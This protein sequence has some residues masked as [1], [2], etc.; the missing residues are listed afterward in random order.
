MAGLV[1]VVEQPR[2][3]EDVPGYQLP[4]SALLWTAGDG[5]KAFHDPIVVPNESAEGAHT[6]PFF[7]DFYQVVAAQAQGIQAREHT[8]QVPYEDRV[9]REDDFREGKLAILY[10][11]PTMELG[12][13][14]KDLNVVNLR[15]IPPTPANYAQRSGRAGRSGQPA[16]VFAY[17]TT[18]SPH[19]QYFFKRPERMV[20][21]AVTP[22]RLDLANEDLVR[23]HVHAIWLAETHLSLG[24]SLKDILDLSG[25]EPTLALL[26]V[27]R[28]SIEDISPKRRAKARA[29]RVLATLREELATSDWDRE[30]WL[31]QELTLVGQ[32][33]EQACERWRGLYRAAMAQ[34]KAQD[35]VIRD[36]AR[37]AEDKR[38]A[39]RLRR[40]AEEQLKLLTEVENIVQSDF[41]S[42]RYFASEG[43]LPGYSFPRLPLSAFIPARRTKQRDEFLSRPRFLAISEFGPRAIVYHEG[44]RYII[45]KVILPVE[46]DNVLTRQAKLCGK[47]GYLHPVPD[48][49]G[50]DVCDKCGAPLVPPLRQLFRLQNVSTKRR[51]KINSDEEERMRQGYEI[52]TG[53]RFAEQGERPSYHSATIEKDGDEL[54][55]LTYGHSATLWRINLGWTR[56]K[57]KEQ[58]GFVLDVERGY[59]ARSDQENEDQAD[60]LSPRTERVIPFVEDRR[61]CLL[62][63]PSQKI[64]ATAMASLQSALK[65]AIQVQF[66]LEDNELAAEP[67]PDADDRR[68][69]LLYESAEGGAGVLRRLLDDPQA[70]ALVAQEALRLCHFDPETGADLHRA[71]RAREDCEA[72]C[73]DCL[74][75]YYNQRDHALLD[76]QAIRDLL[77]QFSQAH[78]VAV[79]G[80]LTRAEHLQRLM[81]LAGSELE[82]KWLRYLQA[83]QYHLPSKVQPLIEVCSTRPDFLYEDNQAA[84][85]IDGPHHLYPERQARDK[86]QTEC[87]E[88]R[89]YT[90]IRFGIEDDWDRIIAQFPYVFGSAK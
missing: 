88:D 7:V 84:I 90:V 16:L 63:E 61:N 81:R 27:V 42:Y 46:E 31:D 33:F 68:V 89:G 72:A 83:R 5:T 55:K 14:I 15:N 80:A 79:P 52:I 18:G 29:E 47:C 13:D 25:E 34:A 71:L 60:P 8:A 37:S 82:K 77:L 38:Q 41:Y 21:G 10:C 62:F 44:S 20:A 48:G 49:G 23:A 17:C 57:N 70:F 1:E 53:V 54:A 11:S 19:D 40:E 51:D 32:R 58:R 73:Y 22:P 86:T 4:A 67:L 35:R 24:K 78:V 26:S 43:F 74:L 85:Y 9:K 56:R 2:D 39:E 75:T 66:Q 59:W 28:D 12:V 6:N 36:A 30:G 3:K 87:M 65:N 69:I 50:A 64:S 76:R 45:N